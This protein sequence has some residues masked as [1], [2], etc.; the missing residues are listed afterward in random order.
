MEAATLCG[1]EV[2]A[3]LPG[4]EKPPFTEQVQHVRDVA[5]G[6]GEAAKASADAALRSGHGGID[7]LGAV[8]H[9][10]AA[11]RIAVLG[12]KPVEPPRAAMLAVVRGSRQEAAPA[13]RVRAMAVREVFDPPGIGGI[14]ATSVGDEAG[15][16]NFAAG[17]V[18]HMESG[19]AR[20]LG[21]IRDPHH[22][23]M[24]DAGSVCIEGGR[25]ALEQNRPFA[26]SRRRESAGRKEF[27]GPRGDRADK[28][29][30]AEDHLVRIP[31]CF[32]HIM[33]MIQSIS[34]AL[35]YRSPRWRQGAIT[36][37]SLLLCA[38]QP[39]GEGIPGWTAAKLE[40]LEYWAATAPQDALPVP[41]VGPLQRA[42]QSGDSAAVQTAAT[43]LALQLAHLHLLG[44]AASGQRAGWHIPDTDRTIDLRE[45]LERAVALDMLDSFF[46]GLRP[47]HPDYAAMRSAYAAETDAQRRQALARNME[48]WRWMPQSLGR[49]FVLVN[50]PAYE[51]K[52]WR[53]G[54]LAGT[55]RVIA[56]KP[57]TPTPVFSATITGVILNPWWVVPASIVREKRGNFPARQGYVWNAGQ[58]SQKPGPNNALGQMK[59]DMPNPY[60]VYLHDTPS[61]HLFARDTRAFSHG[62]VRVGEAL[63]FAAH[64]LEGVSSREEIDAVV[65]TG[66]TTTLPL[67]APLPVYVA[68]F[69][70]GIDR[71]GDVVRYADVYGRD[72]RVETPPAAE[73]GC[74]G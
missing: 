2:E 25:S 35:A 8:D 11:G 65:G 18:D 38:A 61:K 63:D 3:L 64:L 41:D 39:A 48:R 59:L 72:S 15:R 57:S 13:R 52:L 22:V 28:M 45:R 42:R 16:K 56:G 21:E 66:K 51:A 7:V 6:K 23:T 74:G 68:Y 60:T 27:C 53:N 43:E 40:R 55:W 71:R 70:A 36:V 34:R 20:G 9:D 50:V 54:S 44:A 17:E 5:P 49:D 24:T 10:G 46:A 19:S 29:A 32:L 31:K 67:G 26:G 73:Q 47:Q 30:P 69:T 1:G 4:E 12:F 14:G 62:C 33:G 37:G 58:V